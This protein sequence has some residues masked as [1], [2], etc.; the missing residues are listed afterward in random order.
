MLAEF[1]GD[2]AVGDLLNAG[3][4]LVAGAALYLESR[5]ARVAA[6]REVYQRL[7]LASIDFFRFGASN[8]ETIRPLWETGRTAPPKGTAEH[9]VYMDYV[10]QILNL[11]EMAVRFRVEGIMPPP[12]FASWVQWFFDVCSAPGFASIWVNARDNYILELR[13]ILNEGVRLVSENPDDLAAAEE[14][15]KA[16]LCERFKCKDLATLCKPADCHEKTA[17]G[18]R[19]SDSDS[20]IAVAWRRDESEIPELAWLFTDNVDGSYISAGELR[21]GRTDPDGSWAPDLAEVI[22]QE[23]RA[24]RSDDAHSLGPNRT[25][26]ARK[27]GHL[28]GIAIVAYHAEARIPYAIV[29]DLVVAHYARHGGVGSRILEWIEEQ[30]LREG[31]VHLHAECAVGNK[32]AQMFFAA[33]G[34]VARST[35]RVKSLAVAASVEQST[36]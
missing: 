21:C 4:L 7:E 22:E 25:V 24:Q 23:I 30:A 27:D 31:L 20:D 11:F 34:F 19:P 8:I 33:R 32:D 2:V 1:T 29:E 6:N 15:F 12:V 3:L 28:I 36:A 18:T 13:T 16:F 17:N 35:V 5:R 10:C 14:E 26:V 9:I